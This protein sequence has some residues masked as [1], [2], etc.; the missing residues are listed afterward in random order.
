MARAVLLVL[1]GGGQLVFLT[2]VTGYL[3]RATTGAE[4]HLDPWLA[5]WF[6]FGLL[7]YLIVWLGLIYMERDGA[8]L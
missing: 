5:A 1:I 6:F 2:W 3:A 8:S 7:S 4:E